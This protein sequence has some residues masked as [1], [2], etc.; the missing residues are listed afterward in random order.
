MEL[1]AASIFPGDQSQGLTEV[2]RNFQRLRFGLEGGD[3]LA[4]TVV[5]RPPPSELH[6]DTQLSYCSD[7]H[8]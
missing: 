5:V 4:L 7:N 2:N 3:I 6:S 1:A 8:M